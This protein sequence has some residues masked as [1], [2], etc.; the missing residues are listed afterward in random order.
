[1]MTLSALASLANTVAGARFWKVFI[2]TDVSAADIAKCGDEADL[3]ALYENQVMTQ[4]RE[5]D[6]TLTHLISKGLFVL[7]CSIW[8]LVGFV[9]ARTLP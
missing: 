9:I 5:R 2:L 6:A 7:A 1:M 3:L 8:P 4:A